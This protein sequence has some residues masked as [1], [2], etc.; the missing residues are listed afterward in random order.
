MRKYAA[1]IIAI[2]FV[3]GVFF[4]S[5]FLEYQNAKNQITNAK[6]SIIYTQSVGGAYQS[7]VFQGIQ[8]GG[9]VTVSPDYSAHYGD[10]N[11]PEFEIEFLTNGDGAGYEIATNTATINIPNP[12]DLSFVLHNITKTTAEKIIIDYF[13][14]VDPTNVLANGWSEQ[15]SGFFDS[16]GTRMTLK[17]LRHWA[18]L[19]ENPDYIS[20]WA[21]KMVPGPM[22]STNFN[23]FPVYVK[24]EV[25]CTQKGSE[26][27]A[28]QM[29]N[30]YI[31]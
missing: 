21:E 7:P 20:G 29:W 22:F 25:T 5:P 23:S 18:V 6:P 15:P 2:Q 11:M 9:S 14:D 12:R 13:F 1:V 16:T 8:A 3:I 31:K 4:V 17:N 30:L 28:R 24:I 26:A 27:T 19:I 10:T